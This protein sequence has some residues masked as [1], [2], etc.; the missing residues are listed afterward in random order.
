[1]STVKI[2][3]LNND[4]ASSGDVITFDGADNVWA[5]PSGSGLATVTTYAGLP[6]SPTTNDRV[7]YVPFNS[8]MVWDGTDWAGPKVTVPIFGREGVGNNNVWLKGIG[9][10]DSFPSGG[11]THGYYVPSLDTDGTSAWKISNISVSTINL[12]SGI[13]ELHEEAILNNPT[14][15]TTGL[16]SITLASER[17]KTGDVTPIVVAGTQTIQCFWRR[18]GGQWKDWTVIITYSLVARA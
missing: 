2:K 8:V 13:M 12:V 11:T 4:A 1:M 3:Q 14:F 9:R 15:G 18:T 7:F 16:I 17:A 6:G 10:S 5:T